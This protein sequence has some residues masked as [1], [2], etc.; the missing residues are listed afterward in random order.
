MKTSKKT[1]FPATD[2]EGKFDFIQI[3]VIQVSKDKEPVLL[4]QIPRR[5]KHRNRL[6]GRSRM[7]GRAPRPAQAGFLRQVLIPG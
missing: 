6:P 1:T 5:E 3:I 7:L 2:F 4:P